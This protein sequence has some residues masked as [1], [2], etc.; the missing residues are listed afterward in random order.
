MLWSWSSAR[1]P[2]VIAPLER[3]SWAS[4]VAAD[5]TASPHV[6]VGVALATPY[7]DWWLAM[8]SGALDALRE[9]AGLPADPGAER[10]RRAPC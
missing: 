10:A 7:E 4:L 9:E 1:R 2:D 5:A 8:A 3:S 6:R